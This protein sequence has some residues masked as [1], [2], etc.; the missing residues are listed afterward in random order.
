MDIDINPTTL[1]AAGAAGVLLYN[2]MNK[3]EKKNEK[4]NE[5][6]PAVVGGKK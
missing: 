4:K 1:L 6:K 5:K 3:D 2:C